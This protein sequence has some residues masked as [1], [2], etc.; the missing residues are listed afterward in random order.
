MRFEKRVRKQIVQNLWNY[1]QPMH[2]HLGEDKAVSI[3]Q[4][5]DDIA[6]QVDIPIR[7]KKHKWF[8][9]DFRFYVSQLIHSKLMNKKSKFYLRGLLCE[10]RNGRGI[11]RVGFYYFVKTTQEKDRILENRMAEI[12]A[13]TIAT[14]ARDREAQTHIYEVIE[15]K[16]RNF[17][18]QVRK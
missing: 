4:I 14:Q 15:N 8:D 10:T 16:P 9:A 18:S 13:Q 2:E 6:E 3:H 1:F 7:D 17:L 12:K 5:A 11:R